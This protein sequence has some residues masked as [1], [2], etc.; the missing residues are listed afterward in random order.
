MVNETVNNKAERFS[1]RATRR[2]KKSFCSGVILIMLYKTVTGIQI[3]IVLV[4]DFPGWTRNC[5]EK[6][7]QGY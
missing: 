2:E 1:P 6:E 7:I 5:V 3:Q 4:F